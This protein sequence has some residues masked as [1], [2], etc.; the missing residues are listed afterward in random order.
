[1]SL[2][3]ISLTSIFVMFKTSTD[4]IVEGLAGT[5]VA[6]V[7]R[8]F[9]TG[10]QIAFD[11]S[12][13]LLVSVFFYA[14]VVAVP[15]RRKRSRIRRHLLRQ[16]DYFK[17]ACLAQ[18]LWASGRTDGTLIDSLLRQDS[19]R[20]YFT[21]RITS[22]QDRWHV[23]LNALQSEPYRLALLVEQLGIFSAELEFSLAAIEVADPELLE[24]ARRLYQVLQRGSKWTAEYD[25]VKEVS[26]FFWSIFTGWDAAEGY[27]GRDPVSEFIDN[28]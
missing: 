3:G 4:P 14:L 1:M 24:F 18:L 5:W 2:V 9:P 27:L 19:F 15:A 7:L 10:N 21:V 28:L 12:V 25:D 20:S 23:V 22:D 11:L 26:G 16:Y 8:P 17:R 6:D 13:G